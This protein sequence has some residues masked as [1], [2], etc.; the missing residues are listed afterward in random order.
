V[1]DGGGRLAVHGWYYDI[2]TGRIE[3][4]GE[5]TKSFERLAA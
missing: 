5:V 3:R 2:M 4:C 1:D